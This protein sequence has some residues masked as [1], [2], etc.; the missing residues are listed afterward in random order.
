M[1]DQWW[2]R[3]ESESEQEWLN[4]IEDHNPSERD[5]AWAVASRARKEKR[6]AATA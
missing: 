2:I 1:S 3:R 6:K 4:R 5:E